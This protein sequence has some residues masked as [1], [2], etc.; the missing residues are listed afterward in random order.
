[1]RHKPLASPAVRRRAQDA[2]LDLRRIS[3]TGPSGR[4]EHADLDAALRGEAPRQP[5]RG[6]VPK[7]D[8]TEVRLAGLRRVI[9]RRIADSTRNIAHFSYIEEEAGTAQEDLR[10]TLNPGAPAVRLTLLP[11]LV[12]ALV[13][14]V[15][16]FP[17]MNALYDDE[18]EIVQRHGAVHVG[19][20]TQTENGLVVPVLWHAEA[21]GLHDCAAEI[22]R[23]AAAARDGTA[24]RDTLTGSTI[25]ITS[26][27]ALGGIA[28]TPVINRPE[29]AIV[30]VNKISTR[31]VWHDGG[32]V[33]RKIMHLSSS[34]DH[35]VIACFAAAQFIQRIRVMLETPTLL[36]LEA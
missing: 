25:T 34:F 16:A 30:G 26:L 17:A 3:G 1:V 10:Q 21:R 22:V 14:S 8:V 7:S 32:F 36:F 24:S 29:V 20:A 4:I 2:G 18:A 11:F 6:A 12:L 15:A 27:G 9:A 28:T 31:P 5:M 23:L 19:I 33:P 35:R 13:K